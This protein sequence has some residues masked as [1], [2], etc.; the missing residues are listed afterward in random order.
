[1]DF[2]KTLPKDVAAAFGVTKQS[3]ASWN[4]QG[5]PRNKDG[6]TY[7]LPECIKWRI[8]QLTDSGPNLTEEAQRWLTQF[9]MERAKLARLEREK[10]EGT[11]VDRR[12][13]L[14]ALREMQAHVK[15]HLLLVPRV[16][17][18]RMIGK[19]SSGQ[20]EVLKQ[21]VDAILSGMV[22]GF[23]AKQIQGM[24]KDA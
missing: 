14:T 8:A 21:L 5:M 3:V 2:E 22:N 20:A 16:A 9:R 13:V 17:P 1:M 6:I 4:R 15:K 12:E 18:P 19:T 11:L 23:S 24:V 10:V 7:S